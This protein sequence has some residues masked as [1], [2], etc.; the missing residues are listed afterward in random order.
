MLGS[1]L[2]F[3]ALLLLV[4]ALLF[5]AAGTVSW[6]LAWAYVALATV[7]TVGSRL[8]VARAHPDTLEERAKAFRAKGTPPW[9]RWL[10]PALI[11]GA[12]ITLVLAGL[13]HRFGWSSIGTEAPRVGA[14]ALAAVGYA[15]TTWAMASNRFFSATVRLQSDRGHTVVSSGP[16]RFVRHPG[17]AGSLL[18]TLC[19]PVILGS[20]W[21][22][23]AAVPTAIALLVRTA[24]EDRFLRAELAGYTA[25]AAH[26]RRRLVPGVW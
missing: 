7:G 20:A 19:V 6:P 2:G 10:M 4:P 21:A 15:F 14:L 17:Y 24:L 8:L 23:A 13:D 1:L 12:V 16:Y 22:F 11:W 25:Y 26:T 5:A 18:V 3:L 9:D